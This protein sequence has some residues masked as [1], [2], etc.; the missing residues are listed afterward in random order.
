MKNDIGIE[1]IDISDSTF[2]RWL[3][4]ILQDYQIATTAFNFNIY[5]NHNDMYSVEIVGCPTFDKFDDDWASEEVYA[6][7]DHYTM[8]DF[9]SESRSN[10]LLRMCK[11]IHLYLVDGLYADVLKDVEAVACGFIDE[12]LKLL[13]LGE[14]D[15]GIDGLCL[16]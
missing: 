7:R 12:A 5:D 1:V 14:P 15:K 13:Y 6:S 9:Y 10:A 16:N 8:Y 4:R 2:E 3:D 11:K